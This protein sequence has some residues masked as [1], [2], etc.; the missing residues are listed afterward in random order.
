MPTNCGTSI[1][2][3]RIDFLKSLHRHIIRHHRLILVFAA[4]V[5]LAAVWQCFHLRLELNFLS[6]LPPND[7]QTQTFFEVTEA[8]G[9]QS[10]MISSV[11][12]PDGTG[13]EA[14]EDFVQLLAESYMRSPMIHEVDY[15]R[16]QFDLERIYPVLLR[17]LPHLL[18]P[19]DFERLDQMVSDQQI[20]KRVSANKKLLL[21]PFGFAAKQMVVMDPLGLGALLQESLSIPTK[22]LV[23][24]GHDGFYRTDDGN[25]LIFIRPGKPPQDIAFSKQ[26]MAEVKQLEAA[27]VKAGR[28]TVEGLSE[29]PA[30]LH[31]GAYPIAVNDEAVTRKDIKISLITSFVGVLTLFALCFRTVRTLG[32]VALPLGMSIFWTLGF[33]GLVFGRLNL[34][35]CIFSCVL[36]G[37]GI[38]FAIHFINRFYAGDKSG[39]PADVRLA[40]T[41]K[42]TGGGI[43]IGGLTT[44]A[45]FLSIGLSDFRGFRELGIMTGT[46]ILFCLAAMLIVL[47]AL[48]VRS[49]GWSQGRSLNIAGFGLRPL[50]SALGRRP[51][52]ALAIIAI[53]AALFMLAGTRVGF[54]DNL[55]N[56]RSRDDAVLKLQDQITQWLGG[57]SASTL[58]VIPG[59]TET[60]VMNTGTRIWRALKDMEKEGHVADVTALQAFFPSPEAQQRNLE[61]P[62]RH[63]D[64]R[65][66]QTTFEGALKAN[67]L[68]NLSAYG[69]YFK[70][71]S[72]AFDDQQALL[73]SDLNGTDLE[74]LVRMF[75]YEKAGLAKSVIYIRPSQDLWSRRDTDRFK[76]VIENHLQ[77]HGFSPALY[78]LTGTHLLSGALK[79]VILENLT[80]ALALAVLVVLLVL[81]VY[82]RRL[83][84][85][86]GALAPLVAAVAVLAGAMSLLK[87]DFNFINV[88]VLPMIVGIGIDDGVHLTNTHI[89]NG[90]RFTPG[91]LALTGRGV[92]LTSLTTIVGFGSIS[93]SHY[94]GLKSMGY[95][96]VIGV[97]ACLLTSI[98]L[99][100]PLLAL[101]GGKSGHDRNGQA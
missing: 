53:A 42:E 61:N 45:A 62:K 23:Q 98:L 25:Y 39:Q 16:G 72:A 65:R 19:D 11:G 41:Y 28:E 21:T 82:Y 92:V 95:V 22:S 6:L 96:A 83:L 31:T 35:T 75:I 77:E 33:S 54:D 91:E 66:I 30:I 17:Y 50:M 15:R 27:A 84:L 7:P 59:S 94:P 13:P 88:L 4:V 80:T 1:S 78:T 38:D 36:A 10:I 55:K 20:R 43:I 48:L 76:A 52:P 99:L 44:A 51:G 60:Q 14:M 63:P 8:V 70:T 3:E 58:L 79:S 18:K 46:G 56:F 29:P 64:W 86:V 93:L 81:T 34:L 37:L 89:N 73:P 85:L 67:G 87:I 69:D 24:K 101:A 2:A 32:H 97:G 49:R 40:K 74:P 5:T 57:S 90:R 9:L 12:T 100:P 26:L 47:P 68:K 71:L